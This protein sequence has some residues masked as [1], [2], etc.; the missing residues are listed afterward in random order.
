[1]SDGGKRGRM[2]RSKEDANIL[3][4]RLVVQH[5]FQKESDETEQG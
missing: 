4:I 5:G 3:N 1:M 2:S